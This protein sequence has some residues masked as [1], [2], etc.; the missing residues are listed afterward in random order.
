MQVEESVGFVQIFDFRFLMDW[1]VLGCPEH[2]CTI[3]GKCL[4]VCDKN[5]VGSVAQELLNKI[6]W[7][8][9][10]SIPPT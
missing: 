4:S 8:F 7:N 1:H 10:F 2:D 5:F 3:L 9:I 6:S